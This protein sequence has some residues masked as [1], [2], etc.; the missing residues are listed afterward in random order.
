MLALASVFCRRKRLF[1]K[2]VGVLGH[3]GMVVLLCRKVATAGAKE[4]GA[5][6]F[7]ALSSR[8]GCLECHPMPGQ[9]LVA[10]VQDS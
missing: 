5:L 1:F 2:W 10:T 4:A 6:F 3:P 9:T 8:L 7:S